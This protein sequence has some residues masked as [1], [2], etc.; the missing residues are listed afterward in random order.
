MVIK[1]EIMT[2]AVINMYGAVIQNEI[3]KSEINITFYVI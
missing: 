3:S 1:N 2:L